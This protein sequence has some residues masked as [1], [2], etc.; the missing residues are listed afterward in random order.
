MSID[1]PT[2][3][4]VLEDD[5]VF[6]AF[7]SPSL[8]LTKLSVPAVSYSVEPSNTIIINLTLHPRVMI[9]CS[10][11]SGH[12]LGYFGWSAGAVD[13]GF[14][15][16]SEVVISYSSTPTIWSSGQRVPE[17]KEY[18]AERVWFHTFANVVTRGST[19]D[20][21][22]VM[23][24]SVT[25]LNSKGSQRRKKSAGADADASAG[26]D[27]STSVGSSAGTCTGGGIYVAMGP[28]AEDA[29]Q[30]VYMD[31]DDDADGEGGGEEEKYPAAAVSPSRGPRTQ[32]QKKRVVKGKIGKIGK[33]KRSS[34]EATEAMKKLAKLTID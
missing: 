9:T 13:I 21:G 4:D 3:P 29:M 28:A 33:V 25:S 16:D 1:S 27:T 23:R 20:D 11:V 2:T 32:Q 34:V 12:E 6:S 8:V 14:E 5:P 7:A 15:D 26:A 10:T 31:G 19:S 22:G 18:L 24:L 30:E 17:T